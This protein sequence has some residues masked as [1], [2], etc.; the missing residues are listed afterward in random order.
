MTELDDLRR[1]A[2]GRTSNAAEEAAAVEARAALAEREAHAREIV[3][4]G[5][6]ASAVSGGVTLDVVEVYDEPGYLHR[7]V[8]TWRVWAVPAFAAF[9]VGIALAV[10]SGLLV[11]N[12]A[13]RE[14]GDESPA[15]RSE[16]AEP[17]VPHTG[18][19]AL[20]P[21]G[22]LEAATAQLAMPQS[23]DDAVANLDAEINPSTTQLLRATPT[24]TAYA[25][26]SHD[27]KICLLVL[28]I[29]DSSPTWICVVPSEFLGV[30]LTIMR[31][32]DKEAVMLHWDGV[33]VV[34]TI[35][36]Q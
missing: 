36:L 3:D 6:S 18:T 13:T 31:V 19:L 27:G 21:G 5:A 2:Y 12:A 17:A 4:D 16:T 22:D 20:G 33:T 25:A 28:W 8:A 34:E 11:L 7:L 32:D 1:V 14:D 24:D 23:P 10:A 35:T 15:D 9:V 29:G 26:M 30:G